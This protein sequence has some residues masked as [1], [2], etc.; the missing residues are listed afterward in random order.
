MYQMMNQS[1][2]QPQQNTNKIYVS[3]KVEAERR[4]APLNSYGVYFNSEKPILYEV[5]TGWDGQKYTTTYELNSV[6]DDSTN[7]DLHTEFNQLRDEIRQ[8]MQSLGGNNNGQS[9]A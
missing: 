7:S 5:Y 1:P 4:P 8:F 6:A 9:Q 3:S 2:I